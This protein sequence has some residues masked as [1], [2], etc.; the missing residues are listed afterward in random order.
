MGYGARKEILDC[1]LQIEDW[2]KKKKINFCLLGL[3]LAFCAMIFMPLAGADDVKE[4]NVAGKFYPADPGTLSK[5]I[6]DFLALAQPSKV[7]GDIFCLISPHAGYDFSGLTAAFG[8]KSIEG[9]PYSTV[10]VIGPSHYHS[11]TGVSVYTNGSFRT[12]LGDIAIDRDFAEKLIGK[13]SNITFMPE[14]FDQEHSVEVQLPFLQKTLSNFKIVPIV[15]GQ[16]D[17]ETLNN[18]SDILTAAIGRRKDVLLVASTDLYHGYDWQEAEVVDSLTLSYLEKMSARDIYDKLKDSTIQMC[19][20]IG[21]VAGVL[22]SEKLGHKKIFILN[23]T[24]SANVTGKKTKGLWTVGYVSAAIDQEKRED[25]IM[26]NLAQK[27]R[28]LEIARKTIEEYLANSKALEFTEADPKLNETCGVFVTLHKNGELRG[29]I[30]NMVGQGPLYKTVRDMA[31]EAAT[32]DPRFNPVTKGELKDIGIEISVLSSLKKIED[33]NEFK[34]GVHGII[35]KKGWHQGVFLPQV[36]T[37][38]GWTKE[39]FLSQLCTQKA[40]LPAD[41]WKDKDCEKYIYSALVFSEKEVN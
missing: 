12:P 4:P 11:F 10:I 5:Q 15:V 14:V 9:K 1:R 34:L 41:A 7:N 24:N 31:I 38:T 39:E 16:C 2:K 6:D 28:L 35:I 36:A 21:V 40:G 22:T 18:L 27:K 25:V 26:L 20:G 32:G 23:H 30:G 29:C 3:V 8:Y 17:Y 33:I 37:E 13:S 19:G